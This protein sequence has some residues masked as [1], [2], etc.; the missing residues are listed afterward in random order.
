MSIVR[1][2]AL[3]ALM[4][5]GL[6]GP[7]PAQDAPLDLHPPAKAKPAKDAKDV[8]PQPKQAMSAAEAVRRANAWLT[9]A[10]VMTANFVQIGPDGHRAEGKFYLE[11]PGRMRF[12]FAPPDRLEVV[13]DG[14]SIAVRDQKLDTQDLYLIGQ[15]PLKFLLEDSIDLAKDTQVQGVE[16][17]DN[18]VA[19][20]IEDKAALGGSARVELLF[21]PSSFALKQWTEDDA[22]GNQTVVTLFDIDL[23][24]Q[25]DESLFKIDE[26]R[27]I[28]QKR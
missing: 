17:N 11:R 7:A 10:R 16:V 24:T 6:C 21:D 20:T 9:G 27:M 3:S 15:T 23:T 22:Q 2:I 5:I 14:R 8:K 18:S 12:Q 26:Q 28:G 4:A 13:A 1:L 19:I 25:P